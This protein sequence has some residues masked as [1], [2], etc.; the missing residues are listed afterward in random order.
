M[1]GNVSEWCAIGMGLM[2]KTAGKPQRTR[3]RRFPWYSGG[4]WHY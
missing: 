1:S 4:S 3:Y 2:E